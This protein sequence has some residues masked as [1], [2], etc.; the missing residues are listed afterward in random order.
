M[1]FWQI[2]SILAL[3]FGKNRKKW[4]YVDDI[5]NEKQLRVR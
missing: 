3:A 2:C 5:K 1:V 4:R